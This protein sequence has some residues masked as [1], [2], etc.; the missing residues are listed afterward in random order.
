MKGNAIKRMKVY[1]GF[2]AKSM[3]P[4]PVIRLK[5]KHLAKL[6]FGIGDRYR[7]SLSKGSIQIEK[8]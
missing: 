8:E 6:G 2:D 5:G 3:L 7:V 4:Y 1:R